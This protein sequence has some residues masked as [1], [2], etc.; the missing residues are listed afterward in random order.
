[1]PKVTQERKFS[2]VKR[3]LHISEGYTAFST[4][5][6]QH[7]ERWVTPCESILRDAVEAEYKRNG[8]WVQS[9]DWLRFADEPGTDGTEMEKYNRSGEANQAVVRARY[10]VHMLDEAENLGTLP[11]GL[12]PSC[13]VTVRL[14]LR[15]HIL[16]MWYRYPSRRLDIYTAVRDIPGKYHGLACA[17]Y[18]QLVVL[19]SINFGAVPFTTP[20]A[21][22]F[23][24]DP[25][26]PR[27]RVAVIGAGFAG[28]TVARQLRAFG[29]SVSVFE[30]R[31]RTGGRVHSTKA[32]G[33]TT[34]VD[35]GGMLIT[36]LV[37][38]PIALLA[39][40]TE[41]ELH[42]LDKFCV[43]FDID[44]SNVPKD[45]DA[46]AER[47]YNL[48]LDVT[49]AYRLAKQEDIQSQKISL[50]HAFGAA[51]RART[52]L[53]RSERTEKQ[54]EPAVESNASVKNDLN[55]G[56]T[57]HASEP[58][59]DNSAVKSEVVA[60][61][62]NSVQ[63]GA[64]TDSN[65]NGNVVKHEEKTP[66]FD[67]STGSELPGMSDV[68]SRHLMN[69][70][71]RPS[72]QHD[73][74]VQRLLRWHIANLEYA[75]AG[76][77]NSVSLMHWDQDDPYGFIGEH[78]LVKNGCQKLLASL[79]AGLERNIHLDTEVVQVKYMPEAEIKGTGVDLTLRSNGTE[80][81]K[82]FD[83]VVSTIPLGV[84][85]TKRV[86]FEPELPVYKQGA[87]DRLG[88]GGLMKVILEFK[89]SF[90][91]KND[92]FGIL[93]ETAASR[94]EFYIFWNMEPCSGKPVLIGMVT[95]P[96]ASKLELM[97]DDEIVKKAMEVLRRCYPNAPYPIASTIS[98]WGEDK[99]SKGVYT[100]IS[101]E[102]SGM[103]YDLLG[104][105]VGNLF[106]A[107]EHTCRRYPTTC[108]SAVI[109]GLREARNVVDYFGMVEN[110][111]V[112]HAKS[113]FDALEM[114]EAAERRRII[115]EPWIPV[116]QQESRIEAQMEQESPQGQRLHPLQHEQ[117][118]R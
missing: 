52:S 62:T 4:A 114:H 17:I 33:F 23:A 78:A 85:K 54:V 44:G 66:D 15:N 95:E 24:R 99:F 35:V 34:D 102:S 20:V 108:A 58:K 8:D 64:S 6:R 94:G 111:N 30:A 116:E 46:W 28:L 68:A 101:T 76:E 109:S 32:G 112:V 92:M 7:Y 43:L 22:K 27:F 97:G 84:L 50:G 117:S 60:N 75:C 55:I 3:L 31:N 36:G 72:P 1:M 69:D 98:R 49:A 9:Y 25:S 74:L 83:A 12:T 96:T 110:I 104:Q 41:A 80:T 86:Q 5:G 105:P 91:I 10:P 81:T 45:V 106:F 67:G 65:M 13:P 39:E 88:S 77:L 73:N 107:G 115:Q 38:S 16:R 61:G 63:N 48:T 19:G 89:E 2:V 90:W 21:V 87:I 51:L 11:S 113:L 53:R 47:E 18:T 93:R 56:G 26:R 103:D 118:K 37:Q 29:V 71:S 14:D 79:S 70:N 59:S 57:E 42:T 40:Q 100:S 82:H